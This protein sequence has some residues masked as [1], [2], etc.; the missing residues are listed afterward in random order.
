MVSSATS[1]LCISIWHW[2]VFLSDLTVA[3]FQAVKP[4]K[5]LNNSP[6]FFS[7][8]LY[9]TPA[10]VLFSQQLLTFSHIIS[11][12]F[13]ALACIP[14]Y[15][16]ST[17]LMMQNSSPFICHLLPENSRGYKLVYRKQDECV[18][19]LL[20]SSRQRCLTLVAL[21]ELLIHCYCT[22]LRILNS[23]VESIIFFLSVLFYRLKALVSTGGRSV[24][25]AC[26]W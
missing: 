1:G 4:A 19:L 20:N 24:Q 6:D 7:H 18:L 23:I 22:H 3:E 14:V 12:S 8:Y 16:D 9:P 5:T 25:A 15:R 17:Y 26:D 2:N 11:F 13:K 10:A 21:H